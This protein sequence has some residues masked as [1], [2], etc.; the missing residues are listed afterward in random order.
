MLVGRRTYTAIRMPCI[1]EYFKHRN[2]NNLTIIAIIASGRTKPL[3]K[4]N[5]IFSIALYA[6]YKLERNGKKSGAVI[7]NTA[8]LR[9]TL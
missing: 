3:F 1:T 6:I 5:T 9:K 2:F 4:S 7:R 8:N